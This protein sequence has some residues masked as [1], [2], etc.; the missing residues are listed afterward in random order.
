MNLPVNK[1][2]LKIAYHYDDGTIY[3]TEGIDTE[4]YQRNMKATD[5]MVFTGRHQFL[6]IEWKKLEGNSHDGDQ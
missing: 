4:N 2:L 3:Y 5:F 1:K 6:P